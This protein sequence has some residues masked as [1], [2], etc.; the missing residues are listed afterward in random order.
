VA[1]APREA[2]N[3]GQIIGTANMGIVGTGTPRQ[4]QFMLRLE[5]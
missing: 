5:F 1:G 4:I 3:F 2:A